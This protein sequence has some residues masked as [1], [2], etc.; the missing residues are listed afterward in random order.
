MRDLNKWTDNTNSCTGKQYFQMSIVPKFIYR[1]KVM[2]IKIPDT[3]FQKF[4]TDSKIHMVFKGIHNCKNTVSKKENKIE[5]LK[6]P[7]FKTLQ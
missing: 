6:F 2:P 1:F 4:K 3:H 5:R 7:N